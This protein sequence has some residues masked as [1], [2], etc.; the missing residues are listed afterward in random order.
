MP[1]QRGEP[2]YLANP[3]PVRIETEFLAVFRPFLPSQ[4]M[5]AGP[6]DPV[7][8]GELAAVDQTRDLALGIFSEQQGRQELRAIGRYYL[9]EGGKRAEVAFVVHEENRHMGMAGFLLGELAVVAKRRGISGFWASVLADNRAMAGLFFAVGAEETH[10][11]T[12]DGRD[13]KMSVDQILK[14][15]KK[16]LE[17]KMIQRFKR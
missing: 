3:E 11:S 9:D 2:R 6:I 4:G 13:L 5:E 12:E 8:E 14:S 17:R 1:F 10:S 16:F 15:R 7:A